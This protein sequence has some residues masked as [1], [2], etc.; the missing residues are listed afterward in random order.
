MNPGT[1]PQGTGQ[2]DHDARR[3]DQEIESRPIVWFTV[4]L[5]IVTVISM[6][7]MVLM[8]HL[9]VSYDAA[10]ETSKPALSSEIQNQE[11]L[12]PPGPQLQADPNRDFQ[13]MR[14]RETDL[15]GTYGW[16]DQSQ[17]VIRIPIERAI[18]MLAEKHLG[19]QAQPAAT[20][21]IVIGEEKK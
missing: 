15:L 20:P 10:H 5:L 21:S 4:T 1:D 18:T 3:F 16:V 14:R 19:N 8:E 12:G 6:A 11:Q 9:F 7:L 2:G 17:G 13:E